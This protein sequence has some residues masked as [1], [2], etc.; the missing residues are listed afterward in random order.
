MPIDFREL[1]RRGLKVVCAHTGERITHVRWA[2]EQFGLVC[3]L[4]KDTEG[5]R[6]LDK[7]SAAA[8]SELV[9]RPIPIVP[10]DEDER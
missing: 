6:I 3:R 9:I 4:P 2:D 7:S 10:K 5:N 8:L 1:I